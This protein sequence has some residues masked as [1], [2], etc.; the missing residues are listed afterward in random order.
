MNMQSLEA[1]ISLMVFVSIVSY[2]VSG[3]AE[4]PALD[5]SLYRYQLAGDVW[6]VL[7]L[8]NS[9]RDFS[10]DSTNQARDEAENT[11]REIE[12][13]TGVCTYI[14]GIQLA[15]CRSSVLVNI[16][17]INRVL[18]YGYY[19]LTFPTKAKLTIAKPG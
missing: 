19:P 1:I 8:K 11:L 18:Y 6:R 10:F 13:K 2:M 5:D 14:R 3:I 17:S 16:S 12:D 15:S 7:Y 9:F 4:K